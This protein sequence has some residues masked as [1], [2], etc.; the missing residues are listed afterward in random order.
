[1][2]K[3]GKFENGVFVAAPGVVRLPDGTLI[4]SPSEKTL[5]S[6]GY[7]P[8]EPKIPFHYYGEK[9]EFV[10]YVPSS[11]KKRIYAVYEIVEDS[12]DSGGFPWDDDSNSDSDSDEKIFV[13]FG[14]YPQEE[15]PELNG[16]G[17]F[18]SSGSSRWLRMYL[19]EQSITVNAKTVPIEN[20]EAGFMDITSGKWWCVIKSRADDQQVED[21]LSPEFVAEIVLQEAMKSSADV[22]VYAFPVADVDSSGAFVEHAYGSVSIDGLKTVDKY[23][24]FEISAVYYEDENTSGYK[25]RMFLP[26]WGTLQFNNAVFPIEET[27]DGNWLDIEPNKTYYCTIVAQQAHVTSEEP[28]GGNTRAFRI[29]GIFEEN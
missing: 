6:L 16:G 4:I 25:Y 7:L 23:V 26:R 2:P 11:D 22:T 24:A 10:K 21:G 27:G 13:P 3:Y 12:S 28:K 15:D 19:P 20:S 8:V 18:R 1:M 9:V 5:D 14:I 29:G 17:V